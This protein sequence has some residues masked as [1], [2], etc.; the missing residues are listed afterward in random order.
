MYFNIMFQD[1]FLFGSMCPRAHR[2]THTHTH[3][4]TRVHA[5]TQI[6]TH[7]HTEEYSIVYIY[8][9]S[10]RLCNCLHSDRLCNCLNSIHSLSFVVQSHI[11]YITY[12]YVSF[13]ILHNL[14]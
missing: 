1:L 11:L 10:D 12:M 14:K 6:H 3:T 7:T 2:H 4:H 8:M 9:Y 13:I 5:H